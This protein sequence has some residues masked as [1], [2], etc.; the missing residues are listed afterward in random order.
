VTL[1]ERL[2]GQTIIAELKPLPTTYLGKLVEVEDNLLLLENVVK[3]HVDP[4]GR[5]TEE[6]R[7]KVVLDTENLASVE[8]APKNP[9]NED[10]MMYGGYAG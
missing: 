5:T 4:D 7:P 3:T 6:E 2:K 9:S 8:L 1:Y 10:S